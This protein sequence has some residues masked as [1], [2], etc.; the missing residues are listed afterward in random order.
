MR[1]WG[2]Y[3]SALRVEDVGSLLGLRV[4]GHYPSA[5]RVEDVGSLLGLRGWG[6]H[7]SAL[8]V[9]DAG[10]LL[11]LRVRGHH[12]TPFVGL[13]DGRGWTLL[14]PFYGH[15]RQKSSKSSKIDFGLRFEG[16]GVITHPRSDVQRRRAILMQGVGFRV[17]SSLSP[18]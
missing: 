12:K 18:A 15:F 4:W 2:H 7:P 14:E 8:R 17:S 5:P 9:E 1:V 13:S 6:H 10:S 11:G 16:P 3:P